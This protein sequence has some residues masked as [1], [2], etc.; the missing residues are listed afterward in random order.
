MGPPPHPVMHALDADR[1][2][3][4]SKEEIEKAAE[5]LLALDENDDG[6]LSQDEL[7]P[8]RPPRGDFGPPG[9][10]AF[11]PREDGPRGRRGDRAF[12]PPEGRGRGDARGP[13]RGPP[14]GEA[15]GPRV[16]PPGAERRLDLSEEQMD[17]LAALEAEVKTRVKEILTEEQFAQLGEMLRRGPGRPEGPAGRRGDRFGGPGG[18]PD[19]SF[20]P[21]DGPRGPRPPR[22]DD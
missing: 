5:A 21:P 3:S 7:R 20:G 9:D 1:D 8:P 16:L 13:R 17:K 6:T 2:G 14:E 15:R 11:G 10:D 18:P 12:G 4:L 19:A 22:G